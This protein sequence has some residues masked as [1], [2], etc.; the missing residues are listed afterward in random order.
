MADL[1]SYLTFIG[2]PVNNQFWSFF[3]YV[4]I[5]SEKEEWGRGGV[6]KETSM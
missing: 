6:I 5:A 4:F 1:G 2:P 3:K